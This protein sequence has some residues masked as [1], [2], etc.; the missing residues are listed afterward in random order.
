MSRE[1][2]D[3]LAVLCD[4]GW[5]VLPVPPGPGGILGGP[6]FVESP[7]GEPYRVHPDGSVAPLDPQSLLRNT[8][9]PAP[10]NPPTGAP[11]GLSAEHHAQ[12]KAH[13]CTDD[14]IHKLSALPNI[15]WTA[16]FALVAKYGPGIIQDLLA[17][18]NPTPTTA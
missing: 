7:N 14:Q 6:I 12:L 16:L 18:F 5:K 13:G 10:T 8:H 11:H 4:S 3:A 9:M 1:Q 17:L 2:A 15:N